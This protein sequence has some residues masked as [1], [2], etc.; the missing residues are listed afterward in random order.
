MLSNSNPSSPE[1]LRHSRVT[2]FVRMSENRQEFFCQLLFFA[3]TDRS[4][5]LGLLPN[6]H[7]CFL[8]RV[9]NKSSENPNNYIFPPRTPK[10]ISMIG[11]ESGRHIEQVQIREHQKI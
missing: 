6:F 2:G 8:D 4:F 1:E 11:F 3:T 9:N 7:R 10:K 5:S